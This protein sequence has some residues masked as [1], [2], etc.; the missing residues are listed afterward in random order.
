MI[1]FVGGVGSELLGLL[2]SPVA[3]RRDDWFADLERRLRDQ[4]RVALR[5]PG[6]RRL[7]EPPCCCG[8][9]DD[10]I[11]IWPRKSTEVK[12][13]SSRAMIAYAK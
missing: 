12:L 7:F 5:S 8:D 11:S 4:A 10:D 2:S 9:Q 6:S 13:L 1:P 3:E